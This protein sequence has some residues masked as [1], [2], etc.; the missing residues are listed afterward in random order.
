M[1]ILGQ[2]GSNKAVVPS[3][4]YLLYYPAMQPV[5]DG[6]TITDRSGK[7]NHGTFE[8]GLTAANAWATAG[9]FTTAASAAAQYGMIGN[10]IVSTWNFATE[11]LVVAFRGKFVAPASSLS[12]WGSSIKGPRIRAFVTSNILDVAL[13]HDSGT[14]FGASSTIVVCDGAEHSVCLFISKSNDR[15]YMFVDGVYRTEASLAAATAITF[16]G[17][18][19]WNIGRAANLAG[20]TTQFH[21]IH[22]AKKTG[23]LPADYV[24]IAKRLHDAPFIP[25]SQT[26]WPS[27]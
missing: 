7:A 11:C 9:Y 19:V 23:A 26:E 2:I 18:D 14:I 22:I 10:S 21:G 16:A 4:G 20:L 27:T 5:A 13:I 8:A 25:M 12:I 6:T 15:M 1:N 3:T 24:G 17:S